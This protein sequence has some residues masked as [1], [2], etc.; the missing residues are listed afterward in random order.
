M[1][2]R[3]TGDLDKEVNIFTSLFLKPSIS[4]N[5]AFRPR[6]TLTLAGPMIQSTRE[7]RYLHEVIV[8]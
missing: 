4:V 1:K 5:F 8:R 7:I 3:G 6:V 2:F